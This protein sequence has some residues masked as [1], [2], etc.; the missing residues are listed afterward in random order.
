MHGNRRPGEEEAGDLLIEEGS[1]EAL[2]LQA[3]FAR[4]DRRRGVEREHE[5]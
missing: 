2:A 4:I 1:G 3:V 5:G